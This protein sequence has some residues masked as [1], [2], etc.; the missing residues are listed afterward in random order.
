[1]CARDLAIDLM[2]VPKSSKHV[3]SNVSN[4]TTAWRTQ[5]FFKFKK[6]HKP[7]GRGM[8]ARGLA[9]G[10]MTVPKSSKSVLPNVPSLWTAWRT[11]RFF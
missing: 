10:L 6:C 8:Y 2:T 5:R 1:M 3:L 4:L 11:Q 7:R 9:F